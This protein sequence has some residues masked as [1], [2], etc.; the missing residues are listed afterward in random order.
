M[1]VYRFEVIR[2][3]A[4]SSLSSSYSYLLITAALLVS[5]GG[6]YFHSYHVASLQRKNIDDMQEQTFLLNDN[7]CTSLCFSIIYA[8]TCVILTVVIQQVQ[9]SA[10][11]KIDNAAPVLEYAVEIMPLGLQIVQSRKTQYCQPS[12]SSSS[13]RYSDNNKDQWV[14]AGTTAQ[15]VKCQFIPRELIWDVVITEVVSYFDVQSCVSFRVLLSDADIGDDS[16]STTTSSSSSASSSSSSAPTWNNNCSNKSITTLM[17][18]GQI[19]L[20][21]AFPGVNLTYKE[22]E[23]MWHGIRTAL[24]GGLDVS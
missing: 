23:Q 13:F 19:Q 18:N 16:W 24:I 7:S 1:A 11:N 4:A 2:P 17:K 22:C 15:I 20:I 9:Q 14:T 21:P 6:C 8:A 5:V 3:T 10:T 12:A